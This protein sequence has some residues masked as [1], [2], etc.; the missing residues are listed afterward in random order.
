M[1]YVF[2]KWF[3]FL[4]SWR[5]FFCIRDGYTYTKKLDITSFIGIF[6]YDFAFFETVFILQLHFLYSASF[7]I[8]IQYYWFYFCCSHRFGWNICFEVPYSKYFT[9][10]IFLWIWMMKTRRDHQ[11]KIIIRKT[12]IRIIKTRYEIYYF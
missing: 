10:G 7:A 4:V 9:F 2:R 11:P 6:S 5:S 1:L 12:L 3:S 8:F